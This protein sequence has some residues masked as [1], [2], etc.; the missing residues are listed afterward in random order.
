MVFFYSEH[1]VLFIDALAHP[2]VRGDT[3]RS[4]DMHAQTYKRIYF[5]HIKDSRG[6]KCENRGCFGQD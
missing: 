5:L 2:N 6:Q 4:A 3:Q 1:L